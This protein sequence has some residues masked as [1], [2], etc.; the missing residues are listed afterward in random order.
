MTGPAI[1]RAAVIWFDR[2]AAGLR[3]AL[4]KQR[5][6][7]L[8]IRRGR[9]AARLSPTMTATSPFLNPDALRVVIA[10]GGVAGLETMLAL[11]SLA[12]E[13][14]DV[15]FVAPENHFW[16]RPL[17]VAEPFGGGQVQHFELSELAREAGA[18]FTPGELREVDTQER[19]ART[20]Q[21]A[22]IP[23]DAL[24]VACG[25]RPVATLPEALT[26]RGP[27]DSDA[28]RRLLEE[29]E[30]GKADSIAFVLP[31]RVGWP[32]PLYELALLTA[33]HVQERGLRKVR[34]TF[35]THEPQPLA[36]FG[37]AASEAVARILRERGIVLHAGV[38]GSALLNGELALVP[39]G[40][41]A[42]DRFVTL[43]RLEGIRIAG[44][45][46]DADGRLDTDLNG[47]VRGVPDV[48]AAGDI[49]TFPVNQGS[50][51][52]QQADAVAETIAAL[53][54]APVE[55]RPFEPVLSGL[56]LTGG[57]PLYLRASLEGGHGATATA[58][59]EAPWAPA[60]K[61]AARYLSPFLTTFVRTH[62][63]ID[64][65]ARAVGLEGQALP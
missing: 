41:V 13:L 44:L 45:P 43:P 9:R 17:A 23:F 62:P 37:G 6:E 24:V 38:Y 57:A 35:V 54:G 20:T 21:G 31:P 55:P 52:A 49:T 34:V 22:E 64:V 16:Y 36:L 10:G 27:A 58:E 59:S 15:E 40:R 33:T 47:R 4:P 12:P 8:P 56:L 5:S 3:A 2:P 65:E 48:Y 60:T 51:A 7:S 25:A 32:L 46:Q 61:I 39:R 42:A 18:T 1:P 63:E 53:A 30:A 50:M 29:L 28:F 11:R 19:I 14:V 26:F